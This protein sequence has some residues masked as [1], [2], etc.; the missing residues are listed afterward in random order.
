MKRVF[1]IGVIFL[2]LIGLSFGDSLKI[3][4]DETIYVL[5]DYDG[6][7][8]KVDLVNW[9]EVQGQGSFDIVKD[10]RYIKNP[11]LYSEDV[12]MEFTKDKIRF[13]GN[14][15]EVKNIYYKAEVN[16]KLPL[17]FKINYKYNGRLSDP[18]DFL[19]KSGNL[20]I[21][22]YIKPIEDLPFRIVMST[23]F[24]SDDFIL[25][26]PEDFMVMV[27]GKTVRVTG[28]TYPIP[29]GKITLSLK[30]KKLKIPNITLTALPSLPPVDLSMVQ[31]LKE[32]YN[33]VEGFLMLNQAHQKILKG[34]L[35]SLEKNTPSI[36]QE[37]LTL[38][39]TLMFYQNKAYFISD[40]LKTYP[41][42]FNN[43]Y[44]F[45]KNKAESSDNED[46]KKALSLAEEV[47]REIEEN[48]ISDDVRKIG[49]FL[50]DLNF[51]SK[52]A[53]DL[54]STSLEGLQKMEELLN[55][56]LYGGEIEGKKLPGLVDV[57]KDIKKAKD[58]LKSNLT[59]L[60]KGEKKLKEWE[61]KL[62][63]YNFA[64]KIEGA[65]SIV[66]FYFKLKEM[67]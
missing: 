50:A 1:I 20:D 2:L 60:E 18:K 14:V 3:K 15:K 35:E 8:K 26:N 4:N 62:K 23:E 13:Y 66:R 10:A 64:G 31:K 30:S 57:E 47:K 38:P 28:F 36:P 7:Y 42:S 52:K 41:K 12:K 48:N 34:I 29:D 65:K 37:F 55:T 46:W 39:F 17:E 24:P 49:D 67:K 61:N 25:R 51:Q 56:M 63:N 58:T 45:I 53:M 5:L 21:E 6:K 59:E 43:L 40:T 33:G 44:E 19:G 16:R 32:F 9:I 22:I 27:L 54:L 11:D